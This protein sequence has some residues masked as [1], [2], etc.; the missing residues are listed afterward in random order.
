M[1]QKYEVKDP[2]W[3]H[4]VAQHH[5]RLDGSGYPAALTGEA[6][7]REARLLAVAD[8]YAALVVEHGHRRA[9]AA[10]AA[11]KELYLMREKQLDAQMVEMLIKVVGVFPP[12]C[13]V[14]LANGEVAVVTRAGP[15]PSSPVVHSFV[16]PRG[17]AINVYSRRECYHPQFAIKEVL[18]KSKV[19]VKLNNKPA[20]WG[21]KP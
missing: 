21:F 5:E 20:L 17:Q 7:S 8:V 10:N 19:D 13:Y 9:F 12:G 3:L 18:I 16:N 4:A 15:A 2:V 14:K 6:I 11:L 1:L